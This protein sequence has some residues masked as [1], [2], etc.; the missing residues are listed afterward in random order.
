MTNIKKK[1]EKGMSKILL[2]CDTATLLITKQALSSIN[3]VEGIQLRM[4]LAVCSF[5]R[6]FKGQSELINR[7]IKQWS[8]ID[9][10]NPV[11]H[12]SD[13]QKQKMKEHLKSIGTP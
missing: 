7:Q 11:L 4:H 5:C 10:D 6:A 1:I 12:L 2:N 13:E 9:P 3:C 8:T